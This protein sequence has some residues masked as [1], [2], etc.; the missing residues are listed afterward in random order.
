M[1]SNRF[2]AIKEI[3]QF[4]IIQSAQAKYTVKLSHN[5]GASINE[6]D[7]LEMMRSVLGQAADVSFEY[8]ANILQMSSGKFQ[9]IIREYE[10]NK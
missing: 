8:V 2:A 3:L 7:V 5:D 4:Q 1:L 9:Y 10:P 6:N